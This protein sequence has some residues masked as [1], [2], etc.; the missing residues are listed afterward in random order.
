MR[1][2]LS[3]HEDDVQT[4]LRFNA[5]YIELVVNKEDV[6][7]IKGWNILPH[8]KPCVVSDPNVYSLFTLRRQRKY[9]RKTVD[10]VA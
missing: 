1:S 4:T 3:D 10:V 7:G 2:N 9:E 8:V 6:A 5:H